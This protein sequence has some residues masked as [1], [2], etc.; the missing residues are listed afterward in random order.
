MRSSLLSCGLE[1]TR[2]VQ[3]RASIR[4]FPAPPSHAPGARFRPTTAVRLDEVPKGSRARKGLHF[5][6]DL[7]PPVG[8]FCGCHLQGTTRNRIIA[9]A[10]NQRPNSVWRSGVLDRRYRGQGCCDG[11]LA[12]GKGLL[13]H[14]TPQPG[15]DNDRTHLVLMREGNDIRVGQLLRV[16]FHRIASFTRSN[17]GPCGTSLRRLLI[18]RFA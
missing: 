9:V 12:I 15:C 8:C 6:R 3:F 4:S 5:A 18:R 1:I 14:W 7:L 11:L 13:D 16:F 10:I 2:F 17:A